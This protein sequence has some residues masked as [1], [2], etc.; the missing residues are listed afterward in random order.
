MPR[1][2]RRGRLGRAVE[3]W[4]CTWRRWS[5]RAC[6][7]RSFDDTLE[8]GDPGLTVG[9]VRRAE[10]RRTKLASC[11]AEARRPRRGPGSQC[12]PRK[13]R[14]N[15]GLGRAPRANCDDDACGSTPVRGQSRLDV[16]IRQLRALSR[17]GGW[18]SASGRRTAIVVL[19]EPR[20]EWSRTREGPR[21]RAARCRGRRYGHTPWLLDDAARSSSSSSPNV[22]TA[23]REW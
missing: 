12:A 14:F 9:G 10:P 22:S 17:S 8:D 7:S 5:A 23:Q 18:R 13:Q 1:S 2:S 16:I 4:C 6:C 21:D 19:H 15:A 11:T 3:R 20:G